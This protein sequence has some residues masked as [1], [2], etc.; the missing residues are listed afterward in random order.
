MYLIVEMIQ[1]DDPTNKP[2]WKILRE[3]FRAE[4]GKCTSAVVSF[5]QFDLLTRSILMIPFR[6]SFVQQ[7]AH[8]CHALWY[9]HQVL[10]RPCASLSN[11]EGP[12]IVV[13]EHTGE[14][15]IINAAYID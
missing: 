2:E 5:D 6:I 4:L 14:K 11:E 12:P 8:F 9:G 15:E 7:R 13:E 10:Q 3:T 1:Q